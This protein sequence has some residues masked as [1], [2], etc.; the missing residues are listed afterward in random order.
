M[1][2]GGKTRDRKK[3]EHVE[4]AEESEDRKKNIVYFPR[5][6]ILLHLT[7]KKSERNKIKYKSEKK[8]HEKKRK[9]L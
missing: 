3:K 1:E 9:C 2:E 7:E 6:Y 8:E 4:D 5:Y